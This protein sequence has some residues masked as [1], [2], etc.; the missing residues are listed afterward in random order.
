MRRTRSLVVT[1]ALS[2]V[3]CQLDRESVNSANEP[4]DPSGTTYGVVHGWPVLPEG[5]ILGQ[6]TGVGVDSHNHVF[7][8]HRAGREWSR[9]LPADPIQASTVAMFDGETGELLAEWGRDLFAMPHGLTVDDED[10]VWVTDVGLHQVF[11]LTHDG[12]LLLIVGT[13]GVM[14]SD[15]THFGLPTDV[16]ALPDGSIYVSDGYANARVARFSATGEFLF[17][18]GSKGSGP[19]EFDLPHGIA[20]DQEGRVYVADRGNSR[21]QVFDSQG[22]FLSEWN[23]GTLGRPYA[24]AIGADAKAYVIDGGDQP[25]EPPDRSHAFRLGLDGRIEARFGRY[26]NYD[27]Q[28]LLGHDIAVAEDA[29]YVVDAWGKRVQKF[30]VE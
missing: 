9:P 18:W 22:R 2:L 19:G 20:L 17:Q 23:S 11:K 8:F 24:V 10:N 30:V 14:G 1:L 5:R 3:G 16:A 21:V 13:A 29:V 25:R 12:Q 26:G 4:A 15:G 28:F 7:V 27:G 6:A